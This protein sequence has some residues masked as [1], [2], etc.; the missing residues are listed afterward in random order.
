MDV[1][2]TED[3]RATELPLLFKALGKPANPKLRSAIAT[4]RQWYLAGGFARARRL[5]TAGHDAYTP[6]IELMDAW[7]PKL[8]HGRV[9]ADDRSGRVQARSRRC[10]LAADAGL[11]DGFTNGWWGYVSKDLRRGVRRR[12]RARALQP[13][14]LRQPPGPALLGQQALRDRCRAALR[15]IAARGAERHPASSCTAASARS[16]PEPA[17]S[18]QNT[19]TNAS[20]I[21]IPPFPFQNRP[22]FQQVVTLTRKL[23][24]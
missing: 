15:A 19:W 6:A 16:D 12:P 14:V 3:I 20:A 2:S 8:L 21:T 13:G 7:W 9:R 1:P 24:R 11:G 5:A 22:T 23:P 10:C 17:C 18:D 4:L